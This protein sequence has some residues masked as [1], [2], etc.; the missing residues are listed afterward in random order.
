MNKELQL[1]Y[2]KN[3]VMEIY[4]VWPRTLALKAHMYCLDASVNL[5]RINL[6][7]FS[8]TE[9][10][11]QKMAVNQCLEANIKALATMFMMCWEMVREQAQIW[12]MGLYYAERKVKLPSLTEIEDSKSNKLSPDEMQAIG[13]AR[14]M[15]DQAVSTPEKENQITCKRHLNTGCRFGKIQAIYKNRQELEDIIMPKVKCYQKQNLTTEEAGQI[16]QAEYEKRHKEANEQ[17][18][19]QAKNKMGKITDFTQLKQQEIQEFMEYSKSTAALHEFF[20]GQTGMHIDKLIPQAEFLK[21]LKQIDLVDFGRDREEMIKHWI[22]HPMM[23]KD[24]DR[25]YSMFK[26]RAFQNVSKR[27]SVPDHPPR[28]YFNNKDDCPTHL[29]NPETGLVKPE[30]LAYLCSQLV[31][32]NS[33][34][35]KPKY[36][37]ELTHLALVLYVNQHC[38]S[39]HNSHVGLFRG[40]VYMARAL[41]TNTAEIAAKP[42]KAQTEIEDLDITD[43]LEELKHNNR[44]IETSYSPYTTNVRVVPKSKPA[45]TLQFSKDSKILDYLLSLSEQQLDEIQETSD[46]ITEKKLELE[47]V[48]VSEEDEQMYAD[49]I[50]KTKR[51]QAEIEELERQQKLNMPEE[52]VTINRIRRKDQSRKIPMGKPTIQERGTIKITTPATKLIVTDIQNPDNTEK[53]WE[54]PSEEDKIESRNFWETDPDGLEPICEKKTRFGFTRIIE[55]DQPKG[56]QKEEN[57]RISPLLFESKGEAGI[58]NLLNKRQSIGS[59]SRDTLLSKTD[60]LLVEKLLDTKRKFKPQY[61]ATLKLINGKWSNNN[62][63]ATAHALNRLIQDMSGRSANNKI[64]QHEG[65]EWQILKTIAEK[66]GQENGDREREHQETEVRK[67][68]ERKRY[69]EEIETEEKDHHQEE[70]LRIMKMGLIPTRAPATLVSS[71][72]NS[73]PL[74]AMISEA[75]NKIH[76]LITA[77]APVTLDKVTQVRTQGQQSKP[78]IG[79]IRDVETH[80][81]RAIM[82]RDCQESNLLANVGILISNGRRALNNLHRHVAKQKVEKEGRDI[83]KTMLPDEVQNWQKASTKQAIIAKGGV[84]KFFTAVADSYQ[85]PIM[86]AFGLSK[87]RMIREEQRPFLETTKI[88]IYGPG[89]LT[90]NQKDYACLGFEESSKETYQY[91]PTNKTYVRDLI[92]NNQRGKEI[93][94]F[95]LEEVLKGI[96]TIAEEDNELKSRDRFIRADFPHLQIRAWVRRRAYRVIANSQQNNR[97]QL[98]C[99]TVFQSNEKIENFLANSDAFS[100][101]D[102]TSFYDQIQCDALTSILN[103]ILYMGREYSPLVCPQGS[104]N[105]PLAATNIVRDMLHHVNNSLITRDMVKPRTDINKMKLDKPS[106]KMTIEESYG[107]VAPIDLPGAKLLYEIIQRDTLEDGKTLRGNTENHFLPMTPEER[108]EA[109]TGQ[110]KTSLLGTVALIDDFT[111]GNSYPKEWMKTATEEERNRLKFTIHTTSLHQLFTSMMQ[112]SEYNKE[113]NILQPAKLNIRK[114]THGAEMAV[115][116]GKIFRPGQK[117]IDLAHYKNASCLKTLP[118]TGAL[119]ISAIAFMNHFTKSIR[120]FASNSA[121]LRAFADKISGIKKIA[122]EDHPD[123]VKDYLRLVELIHAHS[124]LAVIPKDLNQIHALLLASDASNKTIGY[125][126]GIALKPEKKEDMP[127]DTIGQTDMRL[128]SYNSRNLSTN[129]LNSQIGCKEV[130]AAVMAIT[131]EEPLLRLLINKPKFLLID[132]AVLVGLLN[133]LE[134]ADQLANHFLAHPDYKEWVEKLYMLVHKYKIKVLLV[135]SALQMADILSRHSTEDTETETEKETR[136]KAQ[137]A[138]V[139]FSKCTSHTS[140]S[141]ECEICPGCNVFC[142]RKGNHSDC[143][144][145]IRNKAQDHPN[146]PCYES[147]EP[148]TIQVEGKEVEYKTGTLKFTPEKH[149]EMKVEKIIERHSKFERW[150]IED[151]ANAD[152]HR[153]QGI[154]QR[155]KD[156]MITEFGKKEIEAMNQLMRDLEDSRVRRLGQGVWEKNTNPI[157]KQGELPEGFKVTERDDQQIAPEHNDTTIVLFASL[158]RSFKY[159]TTYNKGLQKTAVEQFYRKAGQVTRYTVNDQPYV[160]VTVPPFQPGETTVSGE[161]IFRLLAATTQKLKEEDKNRNIIFD[162]DL[163]WHY[164]K[165]KPEL[166]LTAITMAMA[167][168][169]AMFTSVTVQATKKLMKETKKT[170]SNT[171]HKQ[172]PVIVNKQRL[173]NISIPLDNTGRAPNLAETIREA[174]NIILTPTNYAIE[175][176]EGMARYNDNLNLSMANA[177]RIF[178]E[179]TSTKPGKYKQNYLPRHYIRPAATR[180]QKKIRK[181]LMEEE[182]ERNK[183][184]QDR[185]ENG[186]G[187]EEEDDMF[188]STEMNEVNHPQFQDPIIQRTLAHRKLQRYQAD[189]DKISYII[190]TVKEKQNRNKRTFLK[191]PQT[192]RKGTLEFYL[193]DNVL[194]AYQEG[195]GKGK[196]VLPQGMIVTEVYRAHRNTG[197]NGGEVAI[198]YLRHKFHHSTATSDETLEETVGKLL[199]CLTCM[200][201][202]RLTLTRGVLAYAESRSIL[203]SLGGE[204]CSVWSH[205]ILHLISKDEYE[206]PEKYLSLL[207]CN[208]CGMAHTKLGAEATSGFISSHCLDFIFFSGFTPRLLI[209]DKAASEVKGRM[210]ELIQNLNVVINK[211]NYKELK[212]EKEEIEKRHKERAEANSEK[213]QTESINEDEGGK[214]LKDLTTTERNLVLNDASE[215]D[216]PPLG[217]LVRTHNPVSYLSQHPQTGTSLG[218]LDRMGRSLDEYL[219]IRMSDTTTP[220]ARDGSYVAMLIYAWVYCNNFLIKDPRTGITPAE[221]H[222]G[223]WRA[224]NLTTLNRNIIEGPTLDR[225]STTGKLQH[226]L[227]KAYERKKMVDNITKSA[228]ELRRKQLNQRGTV[229]E[230]EDIREM[231]PPLTV[232]LLKTDLNMSKVDKRSPNLGP[233]F[234]ISH[235]NN[236]INMMELKTGKI[237]RRSYRNIVELLPSAEL[238]S[239]DAFP[240]WMDNHPRSIVDNETT[241]ST[242][243]T[244]EATEEYK[245]ALN[246]IA[247]LYSFLAPVLPS[248]AETEKTINLYRKAGQEESRSK[249]KTNNTMIIEEADPNQEL[250]TEDQEGEDMENSTSDEEEQEEE[251]NETEEEESNRKRVGWNMDHLSEEAKKEEEHRMETDVAF[252]IAPAI[253]IHVPHD[254]ANLTPAT[255]LQEPKKKKKEEVA[256]RAPRRSGRPRPGIPRRYQN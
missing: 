221:A 57:W 214:L 65:R 200:Y 186:T 59:E 162:A 18:N 209:T 34:M 14:A 54:N 117:I 212:R 132:N 218:K 166:A 229:L 165:L 91:R 112:M 42:N 149:T 84:D 100:N 167:H 104:T 191:R 48:L 182:I 140:R 118:E 134:E 239:M 115:F 43:K 215:D 198:E 252:D 248:V 92:G 121:A 1:D 245:T 231:F 170:E 83:V 40:D 133:Q 52:A 181:R 193:V 4:K 98:P 116:L 23:R 163:L 161:Q 194:Y 47:K 53:I 173:Y 51:E 76:R 94:E 196:P 150:D 70:A 102:L 242:M 82:H 157:T 144:F 136:R 2:R 79:L 114:S 213:E 171:L 8:K 238:L 247:E 222:L 80:L 60:K 203:M 12:G 243:S 7:K 17:I 192:G 249:D 106:R 77:T 97:F 233:F 141:T 152:D 190:E 177:I 159:N 109:R 78:N 160:V 130:I 110:D 20:A 120:N 228:N 139:D 180:G 5:R 99:N 38:I 224:E 168:A 15:L 62:T 230:T 188:K 111:I 26:D 27:C 225:N 124:G 232:V 201:R 179:H 74:T 69:E 205:D 164:F 37:L 88:K 174:T 237:L 153:L 21:S 61:V 255:H 175:F 208:G 32:E 227:E 158:T 199:P 129:I 145:N 75:R 241:T 216:Q 95:T 143:K 3:K 50:E 211:A 71:K 169:K 256:L 217:N 251:N 142:Q 33:E 206:I 46:A 44:L 108:H 187:E 127:E 89:Y 154:R 73:S 19:H 244:Q 240:K 246:N 81:G 184:F 13:I 68:R 119:L 90:D 135:S 25:F 9:K 204:P 105:A 22:D 24:F 41:I 123:M 30:Y 107:N 197:H 39:L 126:L 58:Y 183:V 72:D 178:R 122:W 254:E 101:F 93:T 236:V 49:M 156:G 207:C 131:S 220:R 11:R 10:A 195:E 28:H 189:D 29:H 96:Q 64:A 86:V 226:L 210:E 63:L 85:I 36:H 148:A 113:K 56:N 146:I 16:N 185:L 250:D 172:L 202:K 55:Y 147:S 223:L 31:D 45:K 35:L 67:L 155:V 151:M 128:V 137:Q 138:K 234:V 253:D 235:K 87:Q 6:N 219:R 66:Y 125:S 103:T 176:N